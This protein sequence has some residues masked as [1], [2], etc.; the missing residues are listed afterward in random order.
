VAVIALHSRQPF[1][2]VVHGVF[3]WIANAIAVAIDRAWARTELLRR[4][5]ALL[6]QLASQI[7]NSLDLNTILGTVVTEIRNLLGVDCCQFLWS[8]FGSNQP[9][10]SVTHEACGPKLPSRLGECPLPQF[11]PLGRAIRNLQMLRIDDLTTAVGLDSEMRSLLADWGITSGL[12]L[13]LKTQTGQLGA[14]ICTHHNGSRLWSDHEVE[15]LQAVVDELAIAIEHAELFAETRASALAAQTQASQL[16]LA[17]HDLQQAESRLIQTEKMSSLGQMVAGI[18]HEINN[19]VSFITGNLLHATNYIQDLLDLID[20]YQQHYPNPDPEIQDYIT[21]IDLEFLIEDLP[22]ILSSMQVGA[23]RIHE[24]V[25]SLRNFSRLDE[26][27]RKPVNIHDGIDTTLLILHNRLKPSGN[28]PGIT[29]IK[30]YGNLPPVECYAGQLNQVFMNI[31]SNAIDAL[32]TEPEPRRITIRTEVLNS[33]A[34]I[35]IQ[36]NGSGM[37]PCVI[38]RLFDPFFTTKPVG[39][40]TGLGLAISYQIVVEKHGGL[41]KCLSEPG[42]GAEFWI[43]IPIASSLP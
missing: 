12:L 24:I 18:A 34:V 43:Q 31:L 17:L 16:E 1:S 29:V 28:N 36:D 33:D 35:R 20:R 4:R 11:E 23:D 14:I 8:W 38:R 30:E 39:K 5:E 10:L 25:L 21:E 13:P 15:L 42:N 32:E 3:G 41:L 40:G 26:A 2:N 9:S 22:K 7:R 6:F 27:V 19:P 37:T